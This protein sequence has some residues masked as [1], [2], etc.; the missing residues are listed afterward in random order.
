MHPRVAQ[1]LEVI[2]A[3]VMN[4]DTFHDPEVA[5]QLLEYMQRWAQELLTP[6]EG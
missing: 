6:P 5:A 3:A 4:G 2:D 1:A